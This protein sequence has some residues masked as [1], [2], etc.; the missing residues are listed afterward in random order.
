MLSFWAAFTGRN[1]SFLDKLET[2]ITS[3]E[4]KLDEY[5]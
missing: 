2:R 5:F 3:D 4:D 1:R